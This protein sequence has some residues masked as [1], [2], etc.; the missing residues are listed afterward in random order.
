[1]LVHAVADSQVGRQ[2]TYGYCDGSQCFGF[3]ANVDAAGLVALL[4]SPC[5]LL[6]EPVESAPQLYH[7][8]VPPFE[9]RPSEEPPS[10]LHAPSMSE[11]IAL[12]DERHPIGWIAVLIV[13]WQGGGGESA[14]VRG[15]RGREAGA[16][17]R[18]AHR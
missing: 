6:A 14:S 9:H 2:Q 15:Q 10:S 5:H 17:G 1:M 3:V 7:G 16:R 18:C 11:Q 13:Q 12:K 8:L 4:H